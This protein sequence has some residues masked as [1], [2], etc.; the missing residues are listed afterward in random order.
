MS[1]PPP[2][3]VPLGIGTISDVVFGLA[4]EIGAIPLVAKLPQS[5]TEL[6][7]DVVAFGFSFLVVFLTWLT[8][9]RAMAVLPHETETSLVVN[10]ALL[11]CVAIE[12]FLFYVMVVGTS[13]PVGGPAATAFSLDIGS[14]LL[15]LSALYSLLLAEERR[16]PRSGISA[17]VLQQFRVTSAGR[18]FVGV[19]FLAASLPIFGVEGPFGQPWRVLVWAIG[20]GL[21]FLVQRLSSTGPMKTVSVR[22]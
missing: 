18:A 17:Q 9:R 21:N 11:F 3:R 14:M 7:G 5:G 20:L 19:V 16:A 1:S 13:S 22:A 15:L 4:L 12:P 8:Y 10:V 2:S 6:A